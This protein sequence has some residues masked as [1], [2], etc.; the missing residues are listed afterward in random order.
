[1][2]TYDCYK[3]MHVFDKNTIRLLDQT[4]SVLELQSV[5]QNLGETIQLFIAFKNNFKPGG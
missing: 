4:R 2:Y 5:M 1:M 3:M